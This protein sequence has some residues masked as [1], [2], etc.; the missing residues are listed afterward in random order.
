MDV[1]EIICSASIQRRGGESVIQAHPLMELA[2]NGDWFTPPDGVSCFHC[3]HTFKGPCVRIPESIGPT[4]KY[5][6]RPMIFC[7]F[8][9]AKAHLV[10]QNSFDSSLQLHLLQRVAVEIYGWEQN[11]IPC[12]PDRMQLA[13]FGGSMDIEAFR[14][15]TTGKGG[16]VVGVKTL[17]PPFVP[18]GALT[19]RTTTSLDEAEGKGHGEASGP[20]PRTSNGSWSVTGIRRP[21]ESEIEA[22][23]RAKV[24]DTGPSLLE[25][26]VTTRDSNQPWNSGGEVRATVASQTPSEEDKERARA[27]AGRGAQT[28]APTRLVASVSGGNDSSH[29]RARP[30]K[31]APKSH[32]GGTRGLERFM[33]A[34]NP[35]ST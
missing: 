28:A 3:C 1:Q 22:L 2:Q 32:P 15:C 19:R 6:V 27:S 11:A 16:K 25:R 5:M 18:L 12:A 34:R 17:F 21:K 26:F 7:S 31:P 9:C 29:R 35:S 14:E 33:V 10:E 30:P 4:G 20:E 24:A 13:M 23:P 8:P